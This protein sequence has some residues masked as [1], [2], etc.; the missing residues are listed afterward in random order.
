MQPSPGR[1]VF[2][3]TSKTSQS[4]HHW[5]PPAMHSTLNLTSPSP[6][7]QGRKEPLSFSLLIRTLSQP[8]TPLHTKCWRK[9]TTYWIC[10]HWINNV[11]Y[12]HTLLHALGTLSTHLL[13]VI[14]PSSAGPRDLRK[15]CFRANA[16]T[17]TLN[18]ADS[19]ALNAD[20]FSSLLVAVLIAAIDID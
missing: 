3:H 8:A 13:L 16:A 14:I 15:P 9:K 6:A 2:I 4:S 20:C 19:A 12:S 1:C 10:S 5:I 17:G 7:E 18:T 11:H